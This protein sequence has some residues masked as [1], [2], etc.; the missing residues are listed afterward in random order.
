MFF[1]PTCHATHTSTNA[2]LLIF[3]LTQVWPNKGVDSLMATPRFSRRTPRQKDNRPPRRRS[4][5]LSSPRKPRS[6]GSGTKSNDPLA[7]T[8]ILKQKACC[9]TA[10]REWAP[11]TISHHG[12]KGLSM[13]GA[14]QLQPCDF[15]LGAVRLFS[16][17]QMAVCC[18]REL[19]QLKSSPGCENNSN[20]SAKVVWSAKSPGDPGG[21]LSLTRT[22]VSLKGAKYPCT[23]PWLATLR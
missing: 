19:V 6:T 17:L 3:G 10:T 15:G 21:H 18:N 16:S 22:M 14:D 4:K 2:I 12:E 8:M 13:W 1:Q 9:K 5:C 11:L 7:A 23:S 20:K